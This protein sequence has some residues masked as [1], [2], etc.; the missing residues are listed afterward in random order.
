MKAL[1]LPV[2]VTG[3][4]MIGPDRFHEFE[5]T[6]TDDIP[7][8]ALGE[9]FVDVMRHARDEFQVPRGSHINFMVTFKD[10]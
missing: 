1:F 4:P 3:A 2:Y 5:R 6:I 7:S 10:G 9:A 8:D